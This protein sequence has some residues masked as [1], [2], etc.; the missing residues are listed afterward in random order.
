E[1]DWRLCRVADGWLDLRLARPDLPSAEAPSSLVLCWPYHRYR[2]PRSGTCG[3]R[4]SGK[5]AITA[6]GNRGRAAP[7]KQANGRAG[8]RESDNWLSLARLWERT[9][10]D[11][12][13][14]T[15]SLRR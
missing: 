4:H 1:E 5:E 15:Q 8:P 12:Q 9:S 10:T 7:P 3:V 14:E 6:G 13:V 2:V 11:E